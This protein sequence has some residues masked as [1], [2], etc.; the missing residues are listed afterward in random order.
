[1]QSQAVLGRTDSEDEEGRRGTQFTCFTSTKV[2]ILIQKTSQ[3]PTN[4]SKRA[5]GRG[6]WK[7]RMGEGRRDGRREGGRGAHV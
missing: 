2:Q 3:I 7:G 6:R 4:R 5:R 1:M